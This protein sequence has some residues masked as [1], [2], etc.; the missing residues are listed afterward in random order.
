[1]G[2]VWVLRHDLGKHVRPP[3][4]KKTTTRFE[5]PHVTF[6]ISSIAVILKV[7]GKRALIPCIFIFLVYYLSLKIDHVDTVKS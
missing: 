5:W 4:L 6:E 3:P 1:M 7:D 2:E